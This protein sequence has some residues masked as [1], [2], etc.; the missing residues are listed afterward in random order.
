M[1]VYYIVPASRHSTS[2]HYPQGN[3]LNRLRSLLILYQ[4][5][6]GIVLLIL[7]FCGILALSLSPSPAISN[8]GFNDKVNHL[9]AFST[10]TLA[11]GL[12]RRKLGNWP[13]ALLLG[14]YGILIEVL[15]SFT[16]NRSAEWADLIADG[17][18]IMIGLIALRVI[19][20][21]LLL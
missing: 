17:A 21:R 4:S 16:P 1:S 8:A 12:Q 14:S 11:L 15:Q 5:P 2:G 7:V 13:L 3:P 6:A 10:L 18:G 9:L 19:Q 20:K